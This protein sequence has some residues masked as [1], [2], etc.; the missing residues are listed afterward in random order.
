MVS[1]DIKIYIDKIEFKI[2]KESD[3]Y[4]IEI[5][6]SKIIIPKSFSS[7]EQLKYIRKM[8][9]TIIN[10]YSIKKA[11]V[12]IEEDIGTEVINIVKIEGVIEEL[13]ASYEVNKWR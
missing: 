8:I 3:G 7:G 4:E 10:Q 6:K 11:F 12:N 1:I 9:T 2:L 13:L 5:K